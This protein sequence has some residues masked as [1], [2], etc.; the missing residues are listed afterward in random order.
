MPAA[1]A[2]AIRDSSPS[3]ASLPDLSSILQSHIPTLQHVSKGVRDLWA[4]TLS[5]CLS[6]AVGSPDDLSLWSQLFMLAKCVL[7]SPAA[8]HRLRW[9]EITRCVRTR[10]QRWSEGDMVSLWS[11]AIENGRSLSKQKLKSA[12]ASSAANIRRAKQAVQDGLYSKA[13]KALTSEG[14]ASPSTTILHEMLSKH[15]QAPPPS[16]PSGTPPSPPQLSEK[17]ILRQ[18]KSFPN[19][20]APGPSGLRPSNL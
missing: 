18:V 14:L 1:S 4:H 7:A 9:R 11:E 20:S 12:F 5:V 13:I 16:L 6:S 10:L 15:P 8:G 3:S 17:V 2:S 19:G